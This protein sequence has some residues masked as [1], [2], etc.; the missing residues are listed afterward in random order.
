[1]LLYRT[2]LFSVRTQHKSAT[3]VLYPSSWTSHLPPIHPYQVDTNPCFEFLNFGRVSKWLFCGMVMWEF[4]YKLL[5]LIMLY[6]YFIKWFR[7]FILQPRGILDPDQGLNLLH[8]WHLTTGSQSQSY[9]LTPP[10]LLVQCCQYPRFPAKHCLFT[11][12]VRVAHRWSD[13][14]GF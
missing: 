8:R 1:M 14:H 9:L 3:G 11:V 12:R 4:P 7:L 6:F 2:V 10:Q 5:K 13:H